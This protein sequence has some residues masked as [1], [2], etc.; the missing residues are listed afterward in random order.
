MQGKYLI[1]YILYMKHLLNNIHIFFLLKLRSTIFIYYILSLLK[2]EL[3]IN[4][5]L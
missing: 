3:V 4:K 5:I 1:F 2:N